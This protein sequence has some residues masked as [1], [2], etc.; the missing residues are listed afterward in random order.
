MR[1]DTRK[2]TTSERLL[3]LARQR[4]AWP[5]GYEIFFITDDGGTLCAPCV[6]GSWLELIQD[7]NPGDGWYIDGF[8]HTG[9]IDDP[10]TCDHCYREI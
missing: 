10:E 8:S 1:E 9:E 6:A 2:L 3:A 5:G 7:A 4:W